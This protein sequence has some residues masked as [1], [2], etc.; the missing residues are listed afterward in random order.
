M[1]LRTLG[2]RN[3]SQSCAQR[4]DTKA[5]ADCLSTQPFITGPSAWFEKSSLQSQVKDE[6]EASVE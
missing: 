1:S 3:V 5:S 6:F 4:E 2:Q